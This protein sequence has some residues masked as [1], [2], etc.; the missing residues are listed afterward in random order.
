M[1]WK[2][3]RQMKRFLLFSLVWTDFY[4]DLVK[5][6]TKWGFQAEKNHKVGDFQQICLSNLNTEPV[7]SEFKDINT[8]IFILNT[9]FVFN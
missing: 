6:A 8:E 5:D 2:M 3:K 9:H 4:V 7:L 1:K